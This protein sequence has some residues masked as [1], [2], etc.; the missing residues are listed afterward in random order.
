[1]DHTTYISTEID[2]DLNNITVLHLIPEDETTLH[3]PSNNC[4]CHP[5]LFHISTASFYHAFD[6]DPNTI[7]LHN[8]IL[9]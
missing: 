9:I 5:L 2:D 1:M 8:N 3:A 6:G 4:S 7:S